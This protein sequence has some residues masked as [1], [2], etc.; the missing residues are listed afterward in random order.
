LTAGG[1]QNKVCARTFSAI[2]Q[3]RPTP[4]TGRTA[5]RRKGIMLAIVAR[6][7]FVLCV[8]LG[9]AT[10]PALAAG[11]GYVFVSHERSN[12]VVV[13]DP[14]SFEVVATIAT[15]GQPRDMAF[16]PNHTLLYV[17][18]GEDDVVE[19][20]DLATFRI[21][22]TIPTGRTPELIAVNP[23]GTML[24]VANED[25]GTVRGIEVVSKRIRAEITTGPEPEGLAISRDGRFLYIASEIADMVHVVDLSIG[26]IVES[27]LVGSRP[28]RLALTPD[29]AELWVTNEVSATVS[30]IATATNAVVATIGFR[31]PGVR[32]EDISPVAIVAAPD[33]ST[34]I[35][36]LGYANQVAFVDV[37][38]REVGSYVLVGS[39]AA[40]LAL[41]P[42]G[43]TLYVA[44][45]LSDGI[46]VVDV[47]ARR[48]LRAIPTGRVPH[49]VVV[50]D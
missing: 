44:N 17:A 25:E 22:D 42:D 18:C 39:R 23:G 49:S 45:A 13:L 38:S 41:S 26:R 6:L 35:V 7:G 24:Y 29:G 46:S 30:V 34:M 4:A 2:P 16:S 28:R 19:V 33:G 47:N 43:R 14:R 37:R 21:V 12:N 15:A 32:T 10:A 8:W 5:P 3:V 50:D 48:T 1:G 9:L 40:G 36:S 20:I 31:P 11:T 27:I